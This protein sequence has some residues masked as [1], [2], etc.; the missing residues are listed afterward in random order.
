MERISNVIS[1]NVYNKTFEAAKSSLNTLI[2]W[3]GEYLVISLSS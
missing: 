3:D 1:S 2:E